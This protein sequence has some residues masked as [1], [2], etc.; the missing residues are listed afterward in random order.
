MGGKK[1]DVDPPEDEIAKRLNFGSPGG[2]DGERQRR[3]NSSNSVSPEKAAKVRDPLHRNGSE[4][5][6]AK[7]RRRKKKGGKF[8]VGL[9]AALMVWVLCIACLGVMAWLNW[10]RCSEL[11]MEGEY[12]AV[13]LY[14]SEGLS[15]YL[16]YF[17]KL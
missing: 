7:K 17:Q 12:I 1:V 9:L 8:G 4:P 16:L 14:S 15:Q 6:T 13:D 3:H 11:T 5:H 2:E 10:D